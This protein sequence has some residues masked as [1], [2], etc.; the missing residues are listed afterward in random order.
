MA[1]ENRDL[2]ALRVKVARQNAANLPA[3]ARYDD[4]H[5]FEFALKLES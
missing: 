2:I 5:E 3:A 4:T 1:A